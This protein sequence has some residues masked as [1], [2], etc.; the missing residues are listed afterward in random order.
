F[1]D[2]SEIFIDDLNDNDLYAVKQTFVKYTELDFDESTFYTALNAWYSTRSTVQMCY[3]LATA[4]YWEGDSEAAIAANAASEALIAIGNSIKSFNLSENIYSFP[5]LTLYDEFRDYLI[6]NDAPI[7]NDIDIPAVQFE[8][9]EEFIKVP[10]D[11]NGDGKMDY[12]MHHDGGTLQTY[13]NNGSS[14][15]YTRKQIIEPYGYDDNILIPLDVNS[16]DKMDFVIHHDG[17]TL[18]TYINNGNGFTYTRKQIIDQYGYDD[19]ILIPLYLNDDD[20]MDFVVYHDGGTLRTYF[21]NGN[22]FTYISKQVLPYGYSPNGNKLIP[23]PGGKGF[24][25]NNNGYILKTYIYNG[26]NYI[27]S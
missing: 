14:F 24:E 12:I 25:I 13:I 15:I 7:S 9:N 2:L 20:K 16:D 5:D 10:M 8:Q 17:G 19:S 6:E 26:R 22:G 21:N 11:I 23:L 3:N 1:L 27:I 4:K 18:R